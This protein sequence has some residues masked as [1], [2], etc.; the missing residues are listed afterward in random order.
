VLA[1]DYSSDALQ[2]H[3][4]AHLDDYMGYFAKGI[5]A[6]LEP[7]TDIYLHSRWPAGL[8]ERRGDIQYM[9]LFATIALIILLVAGINYV[10]LV[11]ARALQRARE[12]GV[13]KSVGATRP[14]LRRQFLSESI[15]LSVLAFVIA[16]L[17]AGLLV[18][19]FGDLLDRNLG[20]R[21][22][23][24]PRLLLTGFG[25]AVVLGFGAGSYPAF[26]LS[27]F[28]PVAVLKGRTR[29]GRGGGRL[30][31][32]LVVTQF[33][34]SIGLTICGRRNSDSTKNTSS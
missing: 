21:D 28:D 27:T 25:I 7:L 5:T 20:P 32:L 22:L 10:N 14:Q 30:R 17:F 13:R 18:S 15:F 11:T 3:L 24:D 34:V 8:A 12:V 9:Y 31:K 4:E 29:A 1:P 19:T 6:H 23:F 16:L 2:A 33:A 26:Y